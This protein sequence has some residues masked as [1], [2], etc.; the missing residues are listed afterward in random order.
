MRFIVSSP[1]AMHQLQSCQPGEPLLERDF[2]QFLP[3]RPKRRNDCA[4]VTP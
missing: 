2:A 1:F 4:V 3:R